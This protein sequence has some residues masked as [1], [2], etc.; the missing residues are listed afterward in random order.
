MLVS[1]DGF[2]WEFP[3]GRPEVGES[4]LDTLRREVDEEACCEVENP[5]LMGFTVSTC[6]EGAEQGL[7]LVR[8]HWAARAALG[9]WEP[10][11]ETTHR[12]VVAVADVLSVLTMEPGLEPVY[13]QIWG[14]ALHVFDLAG[15]T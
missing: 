8:S 14:H 9:P 1:R 10:A 15:S 7:V 6:L 13:E 4:L 11:H 12:Q 2:G 5:H 3:A